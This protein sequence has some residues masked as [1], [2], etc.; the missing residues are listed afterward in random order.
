MKTFQ[1][2]DL[3]EGLLQLAIVLFVADVGV[4]R[5]YTDRAEWL[6]ATENLRRLVFF[7]ARPLAGD[8][9]PPPRDRTALTSRLARSQAAR[10]AKAGS[11]LNS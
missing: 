7:C 1:P 9:D 11:I 5:I 4:R 3:W 8:T 6:K 2:R 10:K